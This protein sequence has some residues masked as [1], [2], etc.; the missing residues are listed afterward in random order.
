MAPGAEPTGPTG[1]TT[2]IAAALRRAGLRDVDDSELARSLYASDASLYRVPP[3]AVAFP[4]HTD[5]IAAVREVCA[6]HHVPLTARGAGTSIAGNAVGPGVV[7]DASRH[8]HRVLEVD[9]EAR[10]ALVEPGVVQAN[11]Q[12]AAAPHGLRFG[13]DPSTHNRATL[14]GMIGN[15][16]CGTR[17]LGYGRTS[18]NVLGLDVLTGTG[19]RLRLGAVPGTQDSSPLLE[20]LRGA[21][22]EELATLRTELGRFPRQVSGYSLEHLLPERGFDLARALTGS[23][24]TLALTLGARVRLVRD[25]P[26]R[27][28]VV[29]GYPSMAE[30]ADAVPAVLRHAPVAC[31]G[32][33]ARIVEAVTT[34]RG[35]SAVPRLPRG[36][37]WLLVELAGEDAASLLGEAA[38][39]TADAGALEAR[40][41][42]DTAH[43]AALWKIR[44]DGAGLSARTPA[45]DPAHSGWEDAAV[46]PERLGAYLREFEK[47]LSAH[48]LT[49]LPYGHFGDGCLHIRIDFP[50]GTPQGAGALREFLFAAGELVAR[51]GG[52]MSGEHGDGRARGELLPLMYSPKAIALFE[53]VKGILDPDDLLNPGVI[54]RPDPLDSSLRAASASPSGA[55]PRTQLALAY[56]HD[57][58]DLSMAVHR[59][60][61]VGKCRADT[62]SGGVMCPSF[63]ATREEKDSTRGRARVL[64]DVVSGHLGPDGWRS[65]ALHDAL[66]LCLSCKGCSSDCPTGVDMA[67]YKAEALHQRYRHRPRPRSHYALGL[68]PRWTRLAARLPGGTRLANAVLRSRLLHPLITWAAGV[69]R[70]RSLPAFA[71]A[72]F[73]RWFAGR[74]APERAGAAP[75]GRVVLF[76]DTFTDAFAPA[77]GQ[78]AV[79]VL[80][81]AGYEVVVTERPVCCGL[82][83]ISTGQLDGARR[84]V[85]A[86]VGALLPYVREG[87][88]VVGLE[89]SCTGVLR[90]DA[91]ELLGGEGGEPADAEAAAEVAAATRTLAELLGAT[92]GW[93]PPDLT[94][95]SAVAQPHCHHH[96]V[97]GWD[98]DAAL[99]REAGAEV[100]RLGGCCGLAGNFGVERGH[101]D[102]SVAVASQQ[103]LPAVRKAAPGTVVL[104]DGFSCRTQL[105]AL[106]DHEGDHLAE[107]LARHLRPG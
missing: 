46:P 6:A 49:G 54:V 83:W 103:L 97:M 91:A 85:R 63:L 101:H 13:P 37:G 88:L 78:A 96:A 82:T 44:E 26:A 100:E 76:V 98:A 12:R 52:S 41:V 56:A 70:R 25:A 4:R 30:A 59:C 8:L 80:E 92:P 29:L 72:P 43:A 51:H 65:E 34:R 87:A 84:Q 17:A 36:R 18:D 10:T 67:A 68:L 50:L 90:S 39:L 40:T 93:S 105:Q 107:V 79:A 19:E 35:A 31:E 75:H 89:P 3:L 27:V 11:L 94:G 81:D 48:R 20:R 53:R 69:D 15:N 73:R 9:P 2:G 60:T 66:D 86:T 32:L 77:T 28:L 7:I 47:L 61:G 102:V 106:T 5:E 24:G 74:A 64:Q 99:L 33:D 104:A 95:T 57:R 21:V 38:G 23:E 22:G 71:P 42:T 45:G 14:G 58:G 1:P 62:G 55:A 16:A